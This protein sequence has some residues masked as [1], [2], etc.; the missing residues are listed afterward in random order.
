MA[1]LN[2]VS[3]ATNVFETY[4]PAGLNY[5]SSLDQITTPRKSPVGETNAMRLG[6]QLQ[7]LGAL[8]NHVPDTNTARQ[9]RIKNEIQKVLTILNTE[10]YLGTT[11]L[12]ENYLN[13]SFTIMGLSIIKGG[14]AYSK[15]D[16]THK[17]RV[18]SGLNALVPWARN[19]LN[20]KLATWQNATAYTYNC[21]LTGTTGIK[22]APFSLNSTSI[23]IGA[24][25]MYENLVG[26]SANS[27]TVLAGFAE[28]VLKFDN[29]VGAGSFI[30][31]GGGYTAVRKVFGSTGYNSVVG[32]ALGLAYRGLSL[33]DFSADPVLTNKYAGMADRIAKYYGALIDKK[34]QGP[35]PELHDY[36]GKD[37]NVVTLTQSADAMKLQ[38]ILDPSIGP[39]SPT[40][41]HATDLMDSAYS[42]STSYLYSL[43]WVTDADF[44]AK[45]DRHVV[46]TGEANPNLPGVSAMRA[47]MNAP[48]YTTSKYAAS[49]RVLTG[50]AALL[51]RGVTTVTDGHS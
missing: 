10:G 43:A 29:R 50:F 14:T 39:G 2:T 42:Q 18:D 34:P 21:P 9:G 19:F 31:I 37:I 6:E 32:Q 1:T 30:G 46:K 24:L 26:K 15:L 33:K 49:G 23:L 41:K 22:I 40:W 3:E 25:G 28:A 35:I 27:G 7:F 47:V 45:V 4:F 5:N 16:A 20:G 17:A 44:I 48:G 8:H 12:G 51:M 13:E 11:K 38:G 36:N